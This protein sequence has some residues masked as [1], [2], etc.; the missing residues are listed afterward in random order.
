MA[1]NRLYLRNKETGAIL[2]LCK[3]MGG[4]WYNAPDYEY[5]QD[6]FD[7]LGACNDDFELVIEDAEYAP[8]C[9]PES[10]I[11]ADEWLAGFG[12]IEESKARAQK[13]VE[14]LSNLIAEKLD[15]NR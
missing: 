10:D 6:Y 3:R 11:S 4:K 2:Y 8:S 9:R 5:V 15:E 13:E 12:W 7:S 1:N 14:K